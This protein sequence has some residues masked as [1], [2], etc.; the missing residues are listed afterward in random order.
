VKRGGIAFGV[1]TRLAAEV[2]RACRKA[3]SLPLIV[4]LSPNVTDVTA[5]AGAAVDAGADALTVANTWLGTAVDIR[6]R[7]AILGNVSGGLSGPAVKPLTLQKLLE[8]ARY[9]KGRKLSTPIIASG[10]IMSGEDALEFMVAGARAFA[11]GTALFADF[12]A[13]ERIMEEM[14]RLLVELKV[15][16][17]NDVVGTLELP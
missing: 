12:R 1:D 14:E 10:G 3:T 17:V 8:V 2:T 4:K 16:D 7:K 13:P 6:T 9:L 15:G 5:I 11:I